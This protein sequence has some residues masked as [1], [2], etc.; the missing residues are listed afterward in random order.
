MAKTNVNSQKKKGNV[1]IRIFNTIFIILFILV[2]AG[3]VILLVPAI[4]KP[5]SEYL[6]GLSWFS[7]WWSSFSPNFVSWTKNHIASSCCFLW[8]FRSFNDNQ[9]ALFFV[10]GYI[11]LLLGLLFLMYT[12]FWVMAHNTKLHR[13]G[14]WRKALCWIVFI[15]TFLVF[16]AYVSYPFQSDI[17]NLLGDNYKFY[18]WLPTYFV[19]YMCLF[20]SDALLH[21]LDIPL[22]TDGFFFDAVVYSL[23]VLCIVQII[24]YILACRIK[25]HDVVK[26]GNVAEVDNGDAGSVV[27]D[28]TQPTAV[29]DETPVVAV[30]APVTT[31]NETATSSDVK[32]EDNVVTENVERIIPT[33]RELNI[34]DS[35]ETIKPVSVENLPGLYDTD[36]ETIINILEPDVNDELYNEEINNSDNTEAKKVS[37]DVN[38]DG[39]SVK[40]LPG[41]DEW[42]A[43]P[44]AKEQPVV[45]EKKEETPVEDAKP[46]EEVNDIT[47][48]AAPVEEAAP[49]VEEKK[50]ETPVEE[51][52]EEI[53]PTVKANNYLVDDGKRPQEEEHEPVVKDENAASRL[54]NKEV[55]TDNEHEEVKTEKFAKENNWVLPE[56]KEEDK[57]V[58]EPVEE[59][60]PVV[61]EKKEEPVKPEPV[62]VKPVSNIKQ[63]DLKKAPTANNANKPRITPISPIT[64]VKKDETPVEEKKEEKTLAPIS[65]PLHSTEKSKHDK[66]EAVKAQKVRFELKNYQIKTYQGDLTAE[67]A[68]SKGV[69][70]VQPTVNPV[71]ANQSNEPEWKQK[72]RSDE[73][74]KNGYT[75]V[76]TVD[77]LNGAAPAS[78][79][80]S[81][82]SATSIR[83]MIKAQRQ[84]EEVKPEEK[85][86]DEKKIAKPITP[87]SLKPVQPVAEK[88]EEEK[89]DDNANPFSDKQTPAFHPIAPIAKKPSSRPTIKPVDPMKKN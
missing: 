79:S 23:A 48:V 65:G 38:G 66:I 55:K 19:K 42:N 87:I 17:K 20:K 1:A 3:G 81:K 86:N 7:N 58:N 11:T 9:T 64:P 59:T 35:L 76:T 84:Q 83:E 8:P 33:V 89:K 36:V 49:V 53:K 22:F 47:D 24:F 32:V 29:A 26:A 44:F 63:M 82:K 4:Y 57:P 25:A 71:F 52:A 16:A 21:V 73:I 74:R 30:A 18:E 62:P 51:T 43:D 27:I 10:G 46:T 75:N 37:D 54:E 34:L 31:V 61:E 28:E 85:K 50:E 41:I 80:A 15:I 5:V 78:S 68:F 13:K 60:A 2:V 77:K 39:N 6:N 45:E 12:P 70:K 40:V 88:K 69:T 14:G 72:R 56:Y 67:E